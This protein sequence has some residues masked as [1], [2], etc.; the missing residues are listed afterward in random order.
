LEQEF[1]NRFSSESA[2][3]YIKGLVAFG[4]RMCGTSE[5]HDAARW[6]ARKLEEFGLDVSLEPFKVVSWKSNS[7]SLKILS[8]VPKDVRC[9]PFGYSPSTPKEG[10]E[11]E[12]V[13]V[14][15]GLDENYSGKDVRGKIVL[16]DWS[17]VWFAHQYWIALKHGASAFLLAYTLP[18]FLRTEAFGYDGGPLT[19]PCALITRD[20]RDFI[21]KTLVEKPVRV[22]LDI[23]SEL[24]LNATSYNVVGK[25]R[26]DKWPKEE[27]VLMGHMDNW[28]SG[29]NDN[30]SSIATIMEIARIAAKQR[31]RRTMT[32]LATAAEEA[33]SLNWFYYLKG[34]N[35]YVN[36]HL[37]E[38]RNTVAVLNG[39]FLGRGEKFHVEA[40]AELL[41]FL[42]QVASDLG[43]AT[44]LGKN[45]IFRGPPSDWEDAFTFAIAGVPSACLW[46]IPY[47]EYHTT[48]DTV[49]KIEV[50]KL[51]ASIG[52]IGVSSIRIANAEILPYDFVEYGRTILEGNADLGILELL[53]PG[54]GYRSAKGLLE[55]HT[56]ASGLVDFAN[57]IQET[58]KFQELSLKLVKSLGAKPKGNVESINKSLREI[59]HRLNA[60]MIGGGGDY[61]VN[62]LYLHKLRPVDDLVNLKKAI[63]SLK[64]INGA[65]MDSYLKSYIE[66]LGRKV[67]YVDVYDEVRTLE[68]KAEFLRRHLRAESDR[69]V[70]VIQ[71][72]NHIAST[73]MEKLR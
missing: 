34:S 72:A 71:E 45:A 69:L 57:L 30:A 18:G 7:Y 59:S 33:G 67:F 21:T 40:T 16:A 26:G 64:T 58:Q 52:F 29:A 27:V 68:T 20:D 43:I 42:K 47:K 73:L 56:N 11:G 1:R 39:E 28:F 13:F 60:A 3:E 44:R 38:V 8:P 63:E 48:E 22:V 23:Q 55:L 49:D 53:S 10:I 41:P 36:R 19:I 9:V 61:A 6:V 4:Q 70:S 24:D 51:S 32:F 65:S 50:E 17:D 31:H 37:E 62:E 46:W 12:I 54:S 35:A 2:F 14:S 5:E 15:D 66:F 25:L